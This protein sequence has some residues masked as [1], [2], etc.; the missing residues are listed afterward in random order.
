MKRTIILLACALGIFTANAQSVVENT[1]F[2]DNWSVGIN[3]GA[4]TPLTHSAFFKSMRPAFGVGFSKQLTPNFGL[5]FQG[6]G[7][8]NTTRS[9][10][11]FDVSDVSLLGKVNLMNLFGSYLGTPRVFEIEAVAGM[12]WLHYYASGDGDQN[13]WATRFGMN[14]N[15]NLGESKAWTLGLQPAIVY[16]M[17]GDFNRAK[18]RFNVNSAA[19]EITAGLTYHFKTSNGNHYFTKVKVYN[20]AEIDDLNSSINALR[21]EVNNKN[22]EL[23]NAVQRI[24]GLQRD[25]EDCRTKTV[26]AAVVKTSRVPESIITFRQGRSVVDASQLPNVERVASYMKKHPDTRVVI[27]GYASPEG[28]IE[29]NDRIAKARAE[30]VKNILVKKYKINIDR[31]T[32]EGQ[33][34]GDMFTEPDWNRVSICTIED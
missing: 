21:G 16:D 11:A 26:P 20:Q 19:F 5:G 15:F 4:I 31:I 7:Y 10:T 23:N 6:M 34:V 3:A 32:A 29:V 30:A 22:S 12:G 24:S 13:S 17:Q 28:S 14:F 1:K 2:T 9:K 25:L 18:S 33:G 8:V 27:K